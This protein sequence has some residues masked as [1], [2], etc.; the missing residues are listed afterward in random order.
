MIG[1]SVKN[2]MYSKIIFGAVFG[3]MAVW[4]AQAGEE[5]PLSYSCNNCHQDRYEE[6]T[7]SMHALAV[8]DPIFEAAYLRALQSDPKYREYCMSCH[9]PTTGKTKDF[10]LAKSISIEGVTCSFCH[11]VTGVE[12]NNYI[13]NASDPIQGPY[14]DSKTDAHASAYSPILTKSEFC[15]GCHEFSIN[16]VPVYETYSEW[17]E[18][19]YAAEGKQCQDCHMLTKS[20]VAAK[21][22]PVREKVYQHFW[23]GGHSG[24][25]LEEAFKI[26][27]QVEQAGNKARV[28]LRITNTKVGHKV[29]SGFPSRKVILDFKA[30]DEKGREIYSDKRIYAKTLVD[31]YGNKVSDFWKASSIADDNRIKPKE[32]RV[33]VFEFEV[34]EGTGKLE[35]RAA[36]NYQLEAE[37][38][39]RTVESMNVEIA[40][41]SGITWFNTTPVASPPPKEAPAPGWI[42]FIIAMLAALYFR[43]VCKKKGGEV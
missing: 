19:P 20:G 34:P 3:L 12:N 6:W 33:E 7:R 2:G 31:Q 41:A 4:V 39:T 21:N 40:K 37:V 18:G 30:I 24:Q 10:N 35:T 16:G 38:I 1:M 22:G 14:G 27:S 11:S 28:T 13:F 26:E 32:T 43:K 15:A 25:F 9:S 23:Y 36:L 8:S 42:G 17:K 5:F 29:P